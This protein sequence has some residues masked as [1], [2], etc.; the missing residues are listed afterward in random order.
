M[1]FMDRSQFYGI[2][3]DPVHKIWMKNFARSFSSL[4]AYGGS[5]QAACLSY[6]ATTN[7]RLIYIIAECQSAGRVLLH[8]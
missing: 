6:N 1:K 7:E 2:M 5:Q 4:R 8:K 3:M